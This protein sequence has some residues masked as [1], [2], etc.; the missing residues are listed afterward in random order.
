MKEWLPAVKEKWDENVEPHAQ[1]LTRKAIEM[2]QV[3]KNAAIPYVIRAV[4]LVDPY[5]QVRCNFRP[6]TSSRIK[7]EVIGVMCRD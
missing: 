2:Y 6:L 4:D 7:N 3:S 1:K 5:F